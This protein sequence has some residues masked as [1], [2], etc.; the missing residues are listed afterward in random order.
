M[1]YSSKSHCVVWWIEI[2]MIHPQTMSVQSHKRYCNIGASEDQHSGFE[3]SFGGQ[4]NA[5]HCFTQ[6]WCDERQRAMANGEL[7]GFFY[8]RF[9]WW[10]NSAEAGT[11][12]RAPSSLNYC[13]NH[14]FTSVPPQ[15][16]LTSFSLAR[17]GPEMIL[18]HKDTHAIS[19]NTTEN[20]PQNILACSKTY[21]LPT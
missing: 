7:S 15:C 11:L 16:S 13:R 4:S 21:I 19:A 1:S 18:L 17:F 20:L 9:D 3:D 10:Q 5:Q 6:R 14:F 2:F 8:L 12:H